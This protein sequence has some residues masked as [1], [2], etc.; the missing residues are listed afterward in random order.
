FNASALSPE[1]SMPG[2]LRVKTWRHI[3]I[4][5]SEGNC[6]NGSCITEPPIPSNVQTPNSAYAIR[7][8]VGVDWML[9]VYLDV[10]RGLRFGNTIELEPLLGSPTASVPLL[11]SYV[12]D[13]VARGARL[14]NDSV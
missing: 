14:S 7:K 8:G 12:F 2:I 6:S 3:A 13:R 1:T 4:A 9:E 11:V 10:E 5:F